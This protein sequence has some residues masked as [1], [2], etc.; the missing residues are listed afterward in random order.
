MNG[1]L[2]ERLTG[3]AAAAEMTAAT[4]SKTK[5]FLN[6][7]AMKARRRIQMDW[8]AGAARLEV[9]VFDMT[10]LYLPGVAQKIPHKRRPKFRTGASAC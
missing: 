10:L 2:K 4:T 8:I 5:L 6:C 9:V 1:Q 3:T 7:M